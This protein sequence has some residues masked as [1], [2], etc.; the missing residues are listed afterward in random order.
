M[1]RQKRMLEDLDQD[2]RDHIE[3]ETQDNIERGMSQEEARYAATRKFGN[4]MRVKEQ[5]REVW[6]PVWIGQLREDIRF[7]LRI[8]RKSPGFTVVATLTLALGI[9][10]NTYIFSIVDALLLRPMEFSNPDRIVAL[11]ERLPAISVDRNEVSPANFLDWKAQNHVFDH[12]AVQS[13]WDANLGG[14]EHPEHLHGFLVTPHY[15]A[16]LES[17]PVL[18]RT[19]LEEEGT[20]GQDHVAMLSFGLWHDHFACDLSIVGKTVLLNGIDYTV[21]GVMGPDFNYPSGAQVWGALAFNPQREANRG[22]HYLH[23]VAHLRAGVTRERAQAEM[24][25]IALRLAEQ[26]PQT[27][28]GR[29]VKVMPL[30]E[31]EVGQT[32]APLVV[33]LAAVGLVLLI[34]CA[35]ISNLLLARAS[36]RQR[37]TA[38]RRALGATR[39]R[40]IRQW[41][42]ESMILGVLGGGVGILFAHFCLKAEVIRIP[43]EFARMI[44]GWGKIAINTPVLLFTSVVSLATGLVFGFL[45]S[46][47]A[48]RLNVNDTLKEGAPFSGVV[49]RRG[50]LRNALIVSEVALSLALL[51]TAGLMMKSFVR[52]ERVSPGF[53]ADRLLTMFVA[54]PGAKYKS[55]QQTVS[56]YEQLIERVQ[57][58]PGVQNAAAANL[59]PLGGMNE[60]WTIRMEGV[61][62]PKPGEEPDANYRIVSDSYFR[63]MQIPILRGREFTS[64]DSAKG[65]LVV[66]VNEAFAA[67]FWPGED[68]IGKRMRFSGPAREQP[69]RTVVAVVGNVRNQLDVAARVEMYFPLRQQSE[70]TMALVVRTSSN[71]RSMEES[72]RAQV[73]ALDRDQSVFNIMTMD[74]L[75][76]VS[77]TAQRIGGTL[78]AAFAGFAL[79][80]AATGLFG[81]IAYAMSERTREIGIRL[82]L[83]AKPG[84]V[85]RLVVG[86]GMMLALIGLLVG[87]PLALGMGRA[88]AG[89]LY[90]VAPNDFATF[91]SVAV[92]LAAVALAACYLPARRAMRVD[93][94]V[95]LRYE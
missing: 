5:T 20:L 82:A 15:F 76:A 7:G 44:P 47:A 81:V 74:D 21:I 18:G 85:F 19:F 93:P 52:L 16:A 14:V 80:L 95:A 84:E 17:Q 88:V 23:G 77:V 65:Q 25:A 41:L 11:W 94:I 83:G 31:S 36:N 37:E 79:V 1:R 59:I 35:N 89:L 69:W 40:L 50:L 6:S 49:G 92:V 67:R 51:A 32:R 28:T 22:S 3:R 61:P 24:S 38:I 27:N 71:A 73:V 10:A 43:A 91:A 33:I 12:I 66:A 64:L 4:V 30:M 58:L 42:V 75:R 26:Y 48:S 90:G 55:D 46:L 63:T 86:Q 70:N 29:D 87:L 72:V 8:L 13:W 57:S 68:A 54:L 39:R 62:E 2:I 45:P 53:N 34:A 56:F 9:G 78:M 60:T